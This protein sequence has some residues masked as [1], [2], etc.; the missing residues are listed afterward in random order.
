MTDW[1]YTAEYYTSGDRPGGLRAVYRSRPLET[2]AGAYEDLIA[3]KGG[4]RPT[5]NLRVIRLGR[6]E[7]KTV[8]VDEEEGLRL[9][10]TLREHWLD[11]LA[12]SVRLLTAVLRA[13]GAQGRADEI[14]ALHAGL[15]TTYDAEAKIHD[16]VAATPSPVPAEDEDG[17]I[18]F[19]SSRSRVLAL[20][21]P[22]QR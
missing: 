22:R 7:H 3:T 18:A 1:T 16:L 8:D 14:E 21:D 4:W 10:E 17:R 6:G 5:T 11:A 12:D 19:N 9:A 20:T 15:R 2:V 13:H